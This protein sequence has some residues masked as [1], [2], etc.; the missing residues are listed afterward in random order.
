M[1]HLNPDGFIRLTLLVAHAA[2]LQSVAMQQPVAWLCQRHLLLLK[3]PA[4]GDL[5]SLAYLMLSGYAVLR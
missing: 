5:S 1:G 4:L 2:N 3:R